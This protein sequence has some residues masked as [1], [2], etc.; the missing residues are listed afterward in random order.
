MK[1]A[2][3]L[4]ILVGISL[5][6]FAQNV[7][8]FESYNLPPEQYLNGSD[9]AGGFVTNGIFLPNDYNAEWDS[10]SGWAISNT[11]DV[12][13]PGY[14]NQY[15]AITGGG[16]NASTHYATSFVF[17]QSWIH[18]N[19]GTGAVVNGFFVTNS[20]YAY[21]S[22]L[23]GDAV[24][25]KFGGVTGEDP[26]YFFMSIKGYRGGELVQDSVVF[27]LADYRF[28]DSSLDYIVDEWTWV[29]CSNLG[30]V[31][32]LSIQLYSSDIG[33]F[34]MNTPAYFCMDHLQ[35]SIGTSVN[36]QIAASSLNVYP[37]PT[38]DYVVINSDLCDDVTVYIYDAV[39]RLVDRLVV[40][41]GIIR[42]NNL[43]TGRYWIEVLD[44]MYSSGTWVV[45]E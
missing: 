43:T 5:V 12:T 35:W 8:N 37:N 40:R 10:W 32:S 18:L 28:S 14:T 26:D 2:V 24:A 34:G 41:D 9:G 4:I 36:N 44:Q 45:K 25:K 19:E 15:S 11:T 22:M 39:G 17:G 20:T 33:A 29:D 21:L 38:S 31:D 30:M 13:T 23:E 27:Y 7:V 1:K 3:L 6:V 16:A 42:L